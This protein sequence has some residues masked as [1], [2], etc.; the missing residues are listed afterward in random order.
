AGRAAGEVLLEQAEAAKTDLLVMG[1][2]SHSRLR[3]FIIGGVTQHIRSHA[4]IPV[5]M[6][7]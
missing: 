3:E 4:T 1:G 7:H 2:Y 5:L 6:A